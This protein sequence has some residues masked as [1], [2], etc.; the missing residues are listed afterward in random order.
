[1]SHGRVENLATREAMLLLEKSVQAEVIGVREDVT[2][3]KEEF[4]RFS[5]QLSIV[6]SMFS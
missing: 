2:S 5:Q 6:L 4:A 1:M 3:L